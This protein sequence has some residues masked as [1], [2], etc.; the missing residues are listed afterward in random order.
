MW[1]SLV[2]WISVIAF[3]LGVLFFVAGANRN[4]RTPG[5]GTGNRIG[6]ALQPFTGI[7]PTFLMNLQAVYEPGKKHLVERRQDEQREDQDE[8]DPPR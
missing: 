5:A 7:D 4:A 2:L 8:G 6:N 3:F 1:L